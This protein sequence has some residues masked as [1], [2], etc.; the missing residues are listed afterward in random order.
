MLRKIKIILLYLKS[1]CDNDMV[2]YLIVLT[3]IVFLKC[4]KFSKN[5]FF[6]KIDFVKEMNKFWEYDENIA[7]SNNFIVLLKLPLHYN[8]SVFNEKKM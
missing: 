5:I 4:P 2:Q 6:Q 7:T 8:I 3:L 1:Y